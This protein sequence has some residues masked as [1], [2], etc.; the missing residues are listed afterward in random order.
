MISSV[1]YGGDSE[2][3]I[4][5]EIMLG[6]G[7]L[8]ALTALGIEPT[9]CHM[10]EGHAAFMALERVREMRNAKNMTF[11]EATEATKSSNVFTVHT[12]VAAGSD[13]FS[14]ELIEKYFPRVA[15]TTPPRP[16]EVATEEQ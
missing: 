9:V 4:K 15:K 8:K 13:E 3:R 14:V 6:I 10:N 5:Q 11:E 7:G 1:L 12:P 2:L 16:A